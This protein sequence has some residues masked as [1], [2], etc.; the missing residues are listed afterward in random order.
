MKKILF[1][2]HDLGQGGAK[3]AGV[4]VRIAHAHTANMEPGWKQAARRLYKYLIPATASHLFSCSTKA[5][6]AV[7]GK[8]S[9][10][11]LANAIDAKHYTPNKGIRAQVREELELG[12]AFT[13]M[14]VGRM[15]YAKNHRFLLDVFEEILKTEEH[16]RLILV[17]DGELRNEIEERAA[18][19]PSGSVIMLGTRMDIPRLL[20]AA[21][22]FTFP[23]HFEG[24]P[25]TMIEAQAAGLPCIKSDTVTDECIVTD[26]V[27]SLPITEPALWA[28]EILKK[29]NTVRTDQFANIRAAG[30]DIVAAA[31][32]LTRS[33][34][35]GDPL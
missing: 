28:E 30:Y 3:K 20:Q 11:I 29:R 17:G 4:P 22:V 19:L 31:D 26:L 25:V 34:L 5:G 2:I 15:V 9:F 13:L 24:M 23:S 6:K 1:L 35:N 14:H 32:K 27:T 10:S 33:Y 12:D 18:A 16:A 8:H 21:D 7:F